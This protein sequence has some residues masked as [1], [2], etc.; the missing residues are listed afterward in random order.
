MSTL[1]PQMK[2][3]D[4]FQTYCHLLWEESSADSTLPQIPIPARQ[5]FLLLCHNPNVNGKAQARGLPTIVAWSVHFRNP[6]SHVLS[7]SAGTAP[8]KAG[9]L[10]FHHLKILARLQLCL[11][12]ECNVHRYQE[13][14]HTLSHSIWAH[15]LKD[16]VRDGGIGSE[17]EAPLLI[18]IGSKDL[19][20]LTWLRLLPLDNT[21]QLLVI[22]EASPSCNGGPI[23]RGT[24][25]SGS[26]AS[27]SHSLNSTS[28]FNHSSYP[29]QRSFWKGFQ[30]PSRAPLSGHQLLKAETPRTFG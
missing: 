30:H 6:V 26:S 13:Q 8:H 12:R 4:C 2:F 18:A 17:A 22:W 7:L 19:R 23:P 9:Y 15:Y 25:I 29:L 1:S 20:G 21:G 11:R 27:F 5:A 28:T 24:L 3:P 16:P 14:G 10:P